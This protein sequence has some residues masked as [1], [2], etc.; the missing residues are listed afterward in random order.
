METNEVVTEKNPF[1]I[2][3]EH[4]TC[5]TVGQPLKSLFHVL[6]RVA[7]EALGVSS[8]ELNVNLEVLPDKLI[9]IS[10]EESYYGNFTTG[11]VPG[12]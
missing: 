8:D 2:D 10:G 7:E 1:V 6:A 9:I 12:T 11:K 5:T 4:F 3:K